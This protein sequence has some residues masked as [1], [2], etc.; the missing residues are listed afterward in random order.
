MGITKGAL[1]FIEVPPQYFTL[2]RIKKPL[3]YLFKNQAVVGFVT[4]NIL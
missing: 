4:L 3:D 2:F 1:L